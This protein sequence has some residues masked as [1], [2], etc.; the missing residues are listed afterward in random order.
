MFPL[1]VL[2]YFKLAAGAVALI[3]SF[4]FGWHLRDSD[5]Q[6]YKAAI[7]IE[8][9]TIEKNYQAKAAKIESEKNAQIRNINNQLVDAVSELRKRPSRAQSAVN[10]SCGTG[11]TLS[12]EDAEFLVREAARADKIRSGLDAC[13]KQYEA[14]TQ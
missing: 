7:I 2:T 14:L 8:T 12:A 9:A 10:G 4:Y 11:T 1:S 3:T 5:Y 13:Y 6:A